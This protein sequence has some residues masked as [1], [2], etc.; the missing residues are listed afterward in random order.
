MK[1]AKVR[2]LKTWLYTYDS[3]EEKDFH[4]DT[5]L[6]AKFNIEKET[7]LS[8]EFSQIIK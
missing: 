8:I 5:M 2:K 6:A 3:V 4:K 7:V 1:L